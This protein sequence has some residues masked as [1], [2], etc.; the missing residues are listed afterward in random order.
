MHIILTR[1]HECSREAQRVCAG[2]TRIEVRF[3]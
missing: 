2:K 3:K 1:A